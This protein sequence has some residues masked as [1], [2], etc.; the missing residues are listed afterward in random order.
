MSARSYGSAPIIRRSKDLIERFRFPWHEAPGEAEAECARLQRAGIVDAVMSNDV[1]ALMFGSTLTI[2][3]FSKESGTGT[4]ASTHV[5]CYRMG[6]EGH[7][8][9]IPL[10]RAGMIL[11]AMLS[12]GDYLPSGVPKCGSKL[13]AQ[14]AKAQFGDDLLKEISSES[15]DLDSRL[16]EWRERLQFELEE[17]E[18]GWFTTKHKAVR[19]PETFPDRTILKYYAEPVVSTEDDMT[20]LR[21][22]LRHAWDCEINT[23]AIR[24]LC[25]RAL[26]ME[27]PLRREEGYKA[28]GGASHF[29]QTSPPETCSGP[30]VRHSCS[31]L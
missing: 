3:N 25:C 17:N 23:L 10:D 20:I 7:I 26:R 15:P 12:G 6:N 11:F 4:S 31:R 9:N 18:S 19:I 30:T 1:D 8:S 14:I 24:R 28:S 2:M 21:R 5:T 29:L 27:L 22:R 16:N 13:A